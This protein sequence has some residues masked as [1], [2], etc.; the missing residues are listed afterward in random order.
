M[1]LDLA[2]EELLGDSAA[3]NLAKA[4]LTPGGWSSTP[5][6]HSSTWTRFRFMISE[7]REKVLEYQHVPLTT[8]DVEQLK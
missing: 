8:E 1:P 6:Y 3:L 5:R 4:D 2:D 7:C